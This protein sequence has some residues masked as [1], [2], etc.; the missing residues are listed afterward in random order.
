MEYERRI[1]K[2]ANKRGNAI[3]PNDKEEGSIQGI[4]EKRKL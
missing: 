2:V 1:L 4:R 3:G